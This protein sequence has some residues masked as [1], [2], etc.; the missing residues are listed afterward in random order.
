M[1]GMSNHRTAEDSTET[2]VFRSPPFCLRLTA[3]SCRYISGEFT[4]PPPRGI[5]RTPSQN[6][7]THGVLLAFT[8]FTHVV[9][10]VAWPSLVGLSDRVNSTFR[11]PLINGHR[12]DTATRGVSIA[13]AATLAADETVVGRGW[14]DACGFFPE[15]DVKS[16]A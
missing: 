1:D 3:I 15:A 6:A 8:R 16:R 11:A 10:V 13:A 4:A 2:K 14:D 7:P 9:G 5:V 12:S